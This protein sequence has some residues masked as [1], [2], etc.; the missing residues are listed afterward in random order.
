M[1]QNKFSQCVS[2]KKSQEKNDKI[3]ARI[4]QALTA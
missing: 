4:I 2:H 1:E 3:T